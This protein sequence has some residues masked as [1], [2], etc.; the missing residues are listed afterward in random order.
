MSVVLVTGGTGF[1]GGHLVPLLQAQGHEVRTISRG[2]G[3]THR[4]SILDQNVLE[5]A[6]EGCEVVFHLAGRVDRGRNAFESLRR[7]HVHGTVAV[8]EAA[9]AAG[10]RRVVYASTSGTV[11]VG[12]DPL[13]FHTESDPSPA[14]IVA[15][16]PYYA[17][18]LEA[19]EAAIEVTRNL[20]IELICLNPSLLLGPGDARRS[21]TGDVADLLAGQ[22]PAVPSGGVSFVDV[23][24][25]A[26]VAVRAMTLGEDGSRYL[27]A[28]ANWPL[29]RFFQEIARIGGVRAPRLPAPDLPIR[30]LARAT[31]PL[32]EGLGMKPPLDPVSIEMAQHYWYLDAGKATQVLRFS[33]RDPTHTLEATVVWLRTHA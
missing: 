27:L 17:T 11:A 14:E 21:S 30:W 15:R 13:H 7:L 33:P 18:K 23:R 12:K 5:R 32:F 6:V 22:V 8:I 29:S 24:D 19:E 1:L 16:W 25:V 10:V 4:G 9:A 26:D 31:A 3:A 20:P 28:S 2:E